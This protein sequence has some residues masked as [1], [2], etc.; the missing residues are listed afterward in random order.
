MSTVES[1][2]KAEDERAE[3]A[4]VER[5]LRGLGLSLDVF[6]E[7][8]MKHHGDEAVLTQFVMGFD[9]LPVLDDAGRA[10][11]RTTQGEGEDE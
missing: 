8:L 3:D 1:R 2:Q 10:I 11:R 7:V 4:R 6:D 5:A 9:G